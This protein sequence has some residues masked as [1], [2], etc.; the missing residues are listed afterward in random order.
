[1]IK[2][3]IRIIGSA[4]DLVSNLTV[5]TV[6][7]E[8]EAAEYDASGLDD[9]ILTALDN[10]MHAAGVSTLELL[11]P[12]QPQVSFLLF[13]DEEPIRAVLQ[14]SSVTVKKMASAGASFDFDP[15]IYA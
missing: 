15:Y 4:T 1:M 12:L 13:V 8:Y 9:L 2:T 7:Y 11:A 10:A 5:E 6:L 14:L 3:T